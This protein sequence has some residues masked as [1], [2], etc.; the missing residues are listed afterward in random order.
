MVAAPRTG[1]MRRGRA[2][3]NL[4]A[5]W[6]HWAYFTPN[7]LTQTH[8]T[9]AQGNKICFFFWSQKNFFVDV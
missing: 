9:D 2:S 5:K 6:G 1:G 8:A 3:Y 4:S 7:G